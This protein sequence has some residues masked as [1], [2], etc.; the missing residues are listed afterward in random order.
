MEPKYNVSQQV[1]IIT[2]I[3]GFGRADP[4]VEDF[5]GKTWEVVKAYYVSQNEVWEKT[6]KLLDVYCYDVR[7]DGEGG[8]AR[9]IPELALEP[10]LP[11][12]K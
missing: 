3:D 12:R 4:R 9:G 10:C 1:K 7:L 2:L 5:I 11:W 8:V 6:L